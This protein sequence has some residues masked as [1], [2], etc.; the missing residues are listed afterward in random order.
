[1]AQAAERRAARGA[2][3]WSPR[4]HGATGLHI[5]RSAQRAQPTVVGK[6]RGEEGRVVVVGDAEFAAG[7]LDQRCDGR[8]VDVADARKEMVLYLKVQSAE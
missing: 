1:M 8:I 4:W 2:L 7:L 5:V 3:A 6:Q